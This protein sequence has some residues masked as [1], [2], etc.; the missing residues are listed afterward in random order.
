PHDRPRR[1]LSRARSTLTVATSVNLADVSDAD[2]ALVGGKAGKLGELVR[3]GLPVPPGFVVTTEAYS[4]FVDGTTVGAALRAALETLDPDRPDSV[5]AVS[6]QIR[7][8]FETTEFPPDLRATL[9]A[10][11]L[12]YARE[13]DV[14]F[15]AVRS[16]A[17]AEDLE[18]ASFA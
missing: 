18:G 2:I 1:V 4:A 17:T 13:H 8:A 7:D 10:A 9:E 6:R 16:S 14:R 12:A 5:D 11:Y 3:L 15:S